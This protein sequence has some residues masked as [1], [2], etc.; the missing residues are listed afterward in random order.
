M[1]ES[2]R[3]RVRRLDVGVDGF[4]AVGVVD[5]PPSLSVLITLLAFAF[6]DHPVVSL[7]SG[8]HL[9]VLLPD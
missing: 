2:Y 1:S 6:I 4:E 9:V 8:T 7:Q 3:S 5:S